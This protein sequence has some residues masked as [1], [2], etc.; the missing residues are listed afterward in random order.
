MGSARPTTSRPGPP[1]AEATA[2]V[3]LSRRRPAR[4]HR[5]RSAPASL[6]SCTTTTL[7]LIAQAF[8]SLESMYPGRVWLGVG[9]G[10]A[11]NEVPL[12]LDW[13][14]N[15][16]RMLAALY[17][18]PGGHRPPMGRRDRDDGRRL[19]L[20]EG[21]QALHP[22]QESRPKMYV[23]AFGP[24][25]AEIAGRFGD[26]LWTL[27]DPETAPEIIDA[28]RSACDDNDREPGEIILQTGMRVGGERRRG[29]RRRQPAG[30]RR[31]LDEVY[32][33]DVHDPEDMQRR[34]DDQMDRRGVREGGL[35]SSPPIQTEHIERIRQIEEIGPDHDLPPAD[36]GRPTPWERSGPTA[37][38]V[39]PALRGATVTG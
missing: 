8:M 23:S 26:G 19:V 9:S 22:R 30:S 39:L 6:R 25:A 28:Y 35:H 21:R 17:V 2:G 20:A 18:R 12:G 27:G 3:G 38:T 16:T 1:T 10:E 29:D 7:A 31:P 24:Q 33:E 4:S 13:P 11:L 14:P 37:Q 5:S 15:R 34:A 32:L 36:R